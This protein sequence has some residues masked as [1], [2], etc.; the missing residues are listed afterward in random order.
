MPVVGQADVQ[1]NSGNLRRQMFGFLQH[2][3]RLRPLLAPHGDHTQ[4]GVGAGSP[5]IL[6][7]HSAKRTL[8]QVEIVLLQSAFALLKELLG[9]WRRC[10]RRACLGPRSG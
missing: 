6:R 9:S 5:R 4:I 8:R 1:A 7:K 10:L 3:Q 2:L